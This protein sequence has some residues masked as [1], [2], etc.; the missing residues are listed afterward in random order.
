MSGI[1]YI[2]VILLAAMLFSAIFAC[3]QPDDTSGKE[4]TAP[5]GT[6]AVEETTDLKYASDI[7]AGTDYEGGDFNIYT[8][9]TTN[10]TWYDVD[11]SAT[12]ETGDTLNDAVYS[13]MR[14]VEEKLN[15]KVQAHL[16]GGSGDATKLKTSIKAAAGAYDTAYVNTFGAGSTAQAGY[17]YDLL[18]VGDLDIHAP[19]WDQNCVN[20]MTILNKLYMVTG[21]IGTMYKKSIGV[22]LFNKQM[23]DDYNLDS[24]YALVSDMKWTIDKFTEMGRQVSQ[25]L[26]GDGKWTVDDKYG[27]LYYCDMIALGLIGGG[28][29]I[30][31]KDEED[32]PY[33][34]F[35]NDTTQKIWETYI[36]LLYDPSLSLSWSKIGVPND[37]IIAMFQNN[38]G[39]FNFNEFHAIQNMRE[40]DTDFGILPVPL[41]T[42]G[43]SSYFHT[44]NPHVAAMI[45]IPV[46]APDVSKSAIVLD[47]LGSESKNILTPAYNEVYLKTKGTRDDDSE[48]VLDIVFATLKYDVGYLYNWGNVGT[49]TLTMVNAYNPD[50]ASQYAKIEKAAETAMQKAIDAY[51]LLE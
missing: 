45:C 5:A 38:Q 33:I 17:L 40:M 23:I 50:L 51:L 39:L 26:N 35:Y 7:P 19:W 14:T 3:A 9:D 49:F 22:I 44:I 25:D 12:E 8:Y 42:E 47:A 32:L 31:S 11:F 15:V 41:Y 30:C 10:G 20:G 24:P 28:V 13:R 29:N 48:A 34:S 2:S 21:D 27:L 16:M 4:T 37:D 43:Q 18:S 36:E 6:D 1:K 46:D